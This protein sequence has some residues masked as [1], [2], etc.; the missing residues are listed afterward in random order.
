MLIHF[1][2]KIS[3]NFSDIFE[4]YAIA[5][6][7]NIDN[8]TFSGTVDDIFKNFDQ[9]ILSVSDT[10]DP[11]SILGGINLVVPFAKN[12]GA[13]VVAYEGGQGLNGDKNQAQKIAAQADPRMY[14]ETKKIF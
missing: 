12:L 8:D 2:R 14:T 11:N 9:Q 6:Y 7:F 1:S 10:S 13:K 4:F 5:P 3:E